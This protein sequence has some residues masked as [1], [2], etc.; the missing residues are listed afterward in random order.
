MASYT[1]KYR[2]ATTFKNS[3]P[4]TVLDNTTRFD[5]TRINAMAQAAEEFLLGFGEPFEWRDR[6]KNAFDAAV[7]VIMLR[8]VNAPSTAIDT[9]LGEH[10]LEFQD[11][12]KI[13]QVQ[14]WMKVSA[15]SKR[16]M[17]KA[18]LVRC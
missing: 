10:E 11:L 2:N 9:K 6:E 7:R 16:G 3:T 4:S 13:P 8:E 17:R 12:D 18:R 1:S 15:S 14:N 5:S